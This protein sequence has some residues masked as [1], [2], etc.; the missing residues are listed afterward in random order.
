M[1]LLGELEHEVMSVLWTREDAATIREVVEIVETRREVAY[2]TVMTI[3]NRLVE[4]GLLSRS[5]KE[6]P[7]RFLPCQNEQETYRRLAGTIL[8][9]IHANFGDL[10]IACFA[11]EAEKIKRSI[12]L[13][14]TYPVFMG[15]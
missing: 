2:T 7:H 3:M 13:A 9:E 4:K 1:R 5:E 15:V 8:T 12:V 14:K 10:A 6:T 11:E